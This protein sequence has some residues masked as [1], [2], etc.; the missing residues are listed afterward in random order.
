MEG[1]PSKQEYTGE[2][3]HPAVEHAYTKALKLFEGA[4]INPNDFTKIYTEDEIA[5][6]IGAVERKEA[7]F[8]LDANKK[9]A[10]VL[11]AIMCYQIGHGDWFGENVSAIKSSKYDDYFN[12]SDLILELTNLN[13]QLSHLS[14]SVDVT[15]GTA[16]EEEKFKNI[17]ENIDR[18]S[19]GEIKYFHLGKEGPQKKLTQVPQVVIG[20]EK[21]R[22]VELAGL[23]SDNSTTATLRDRNEE[24]LKNHP[25]QNVILSEMIYQLTVF[26]NYAE[27]TG[28][29]SLL[30]HYDKNLLI[31]EDIRREKG[32][33]STGDLRNDGVYVAIRESMKMFRAEETK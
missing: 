9:Y 7:K 15:F 26:R 11:E 1:I 13:E 20:V 5:R 32:V 28:K 23:W 33:V 31:L 21:S 14:L 27:N 17:K 10:E 19:L 8:I 22:I 30:P 16:T 3:V 2:V 4:E 18:E 24:S 12:G 29:K 25:I 6:D